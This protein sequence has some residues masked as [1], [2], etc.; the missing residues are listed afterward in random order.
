MSLFHLTTRPRLCIGIASQSRPQKSLS[1]S[2]SFATS[3]RIQTRPNSIASRYL[4]VS[5]KQVRF[6]TTSTSSSSNSSRTNVANFFNR[7]MAKTGD[8]ARHA[9]TTT[10]VKSQSA[11]RWARFAWWFRASRIPILIGSIYS[12]GYQQ[13]V[14]DSV[15]NPNK[16]QQS[17]FEACCTDMGITSGD[18][19]DII[20]ERR[21]PSN[22]RNIGWFRSLMEDEEETGPEIKDPRANRVASVGRDIVRS[23]RQYIRE[24]LDF[25]MKKKQEELILLAKKE[26]REISKAEAYKAI[27]EDEE[28]QKWTESFERIEGYTHDGIKNWQCK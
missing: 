12:L 24:K 20:W 4:L 28:V 10:G 17:S 23:A 6:S 14:L 18:D 19:I 15:R 1:L 13:G 16:I 21:P 3:S 27:S 9:A 22:L 11:Q 7:D 8:P 25:A 2:R 5:H 26:N